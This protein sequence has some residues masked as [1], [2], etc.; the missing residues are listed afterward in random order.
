MTQ[1]DPDPSVPDP[2]PPFDPVLDPYDPPEPLPQ[3]ED[4][5]LPP[6]G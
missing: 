2:V 6:E 5:D 1:P 3:G 4:P